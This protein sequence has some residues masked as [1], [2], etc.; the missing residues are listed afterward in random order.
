MQ[1]GRSFPVQDAAEAFTAW[2]E[3]LGQFLPAS[4]FRASPENSRRAGAGALSPG[5]EPRTGARTTMER[6][7]R[8]PGFKVAMETMTS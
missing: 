2:L 7:L 6:P 4:G 5:P 8:V 3:R 1:H